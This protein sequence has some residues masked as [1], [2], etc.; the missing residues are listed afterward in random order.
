MEW[1]KFNY[2]FYSKKLKIYLLYNSLT[3]VLIKLNK[4]S[5]TRLKNYIKNPNLLSQ[6]NEETQTLFTGK[7]FVKSNNSEINKIK[8]FNNTA[9]HDNSKLSL[10]IAPTRYCNFNCFYCYE[11][12]RKKVY[13][14]P[15][16]EQSI[17]RFVTEMKNIESLTLHWFGGEPLLA[18]KTIYRLTKSFKKNIENYNATMT[19]NG[20]LLNKIVNDFETLS[21]RSVQITV[22]GNQD[23][24]NKR[25]PH[26]T[27]NNSFQKI[28]NNVKSIVKDN[29]C[30]V[31][32]V[33]VNIDKNNK[34][35]YKEVKSIFHK[36]HPTKLKVY[37]AY[38]VDY[39]SSCVPNSCLEHSEKSDYIKDLFYKKEIYSDGIYPNT[40]FHGCMMRMTNSFLIGPDGEVY[41][42]WHHLGENELVIGNIAN[43]PFITN[44]ELN[45]DF[46]NESDSLYSE[47]CNNCFMFPS[48]WGG[49]PDTRIKL[50]D[51]MYPEVCPPFKLNTEEFLE[52]HYLHKTKTT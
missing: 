19:T 38:V 27:F 21:I 4:E 1:S 40:K 33:R 50:K 35:E 49:C 6:D 26:T 44:L 17:I 41:K 20:Y 37:P 31:I 8:Y 29:H 13:M 2:L 30:P 24:H 9:R 15:A 32:Y 43:K 46:L 3:N 47:K 28:V 45:A 51:K 11:K 48:C 10:T 14:S 18:Y 5:Y 23:T 34:D 36:I 22:D 7:F 25:R 12:D 16:I 52:M 39:L 42:C